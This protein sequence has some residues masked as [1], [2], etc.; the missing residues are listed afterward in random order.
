MKMRMTARSAEQAGRT[1][2]VRGGGPVTATSKARPKPLSHDERTS[3]DTCGCTF[4]PIVQRQPA[5]QQSATQQNQL[6]VKASTR[7]PEAGRQAGAAEAAPSRI[8]ATSPS[9]V[10]HRV[11]RVLDSPGRLLDRATTDAMRSRLGHDFSSVRI[12]DDAQAAASANDIG[13]RAYA[14][15]NHVVFGANDFSL[16]SPKGQDLLTH[17]LIHVMQQSSASAGRPSRIS[18]PSD[19]AEVQACSMRRP[20]SVQVAAPGTVH[21]DPVNKTVP[22]DP[23]KPGNAARANLAGALNDDRYATSHITVKSST[24]PKAKMIGT[25][26]RTECCENTND[27]PVRRPA[28]TTNIRLGN[29]QRQLDL[30]P[31]PGRAMRTDKLNGPNGIRASGLL[32]RKARD[33]NGVADGAEQAVGAASSSSGTALP[34]PLMRKFEGSLGAD[35]SGVRVHTGDSSVAANE[36]VGAR[37]YTLGQDIHFGAG[38]YDPSSAGGQH[39]LAHEVAHTQQQSGG[40]GQAQFKLE[41]SEPGDQSETE[42]DRAAD[43]MV[44]GG[45]AT[46]TGASG[47]AH[48]K[49]MRQE[50]DKVT[51]L[52]EK[53]FKAEDLKTEIKGSLDVSPVGNRHLFRA[54]SIEAKSQVDMFVPDGKNLG[55]IG[56]PD[57]IVNAGLIQTLLSSQRIAVYR[58]ASGK[59]TE[60]PRVMGQIRDARDFVYNDDPNAVRF[61]KV[62]P[63]FYDMPVRLTVKD[64]TN[65]VSTIDQPKHSALSQLEDGSQL[66]ALKGADN[67]N[68]SIGLVRGANQV[69][70]KPK[71]WS[72]NWDKEVGNA[73]SGPKDPLSVEKD[74]AKQ[75]AVVDNNP[76][77]AN[78][79][80]AENVD[81][82]KRAIELPARDLLQLLVKVRERDAESGKYIEQA[83][84][85]KNPTFVAQVVLKKNP[86]GNADDWEL[87]VLPVGTKNATEQKLWTKHLTVDVQFNLLDAFTP[88]AIKGDTTLQFVLRPEGATGVP[89]INR[90]PYLSGI[91]SEMRYP[92]EGT[93]KVITNEGSQIEAD[94]HVK[95]K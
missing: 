67:F 91:S 31:A 53:W 42:A 29:A 59:T 74:E 73:A 35:L 46:V 90:V 4:G 50:A 28:Y 89:L 24:S 54:P 27:D 80:S 2:A 86:E 85:K 75:G 6:G 64:P 20:F 83:L 13:A 14:F 48:R 33:S 66:V 5:P 77:Y 17:E 63:P 72:L 47:G 15:G 43:A 10:P 81:S 9:E 49:V 52:D 38:Q 94:I 8:S 65:T 41:V 58:D 87:N 36:A 12:H 61:S 56:D 1:L 16:A 18:S 32:S 60:K 76:D 69:A 7:L 57:H 3:D 11:A 45:V 25:I 26:F 30:A 40:G 34:D 68:M 79:V 84:V 23:K 39:L 62:P 44:A 37:A 78:K 82:L 22:A 88:A 70:I 51:G 71:N 21:R 92:F 55:A 95:L 93:S 19:P